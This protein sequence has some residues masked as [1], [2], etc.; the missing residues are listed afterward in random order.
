[1]ARF[2]SCFLISAAVL[3]ILMVMGLAIHRS[4]KWGPPPPPGVDP[5]GQ[6][7]HQI[8]NLRQRVYSRVHGR[9][10]RGRV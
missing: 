9:G 8:I 3:M 10:G 4:G 7:R 5:G 2:S 6:H 1:M